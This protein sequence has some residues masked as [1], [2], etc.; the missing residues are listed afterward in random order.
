MKIALINASPKKVESASSTILN[1]LKSVLPSEYSIEDFSIHSPY[2]TEEEIKELS[3]YSVWVFAF[4]LYV[5]GIPSHLLSCLCQI[6]QYGIKDK[7]IRVYSIVNSGFYEGKQNSN[8]LEILKNWCDKVGFTWGM[9]IGF[10]GGGALASMK[11]V[12][13]GKGPKAAFGKSCTELSNVVVAQ[14]SKENVYITIGFPRILYKM[15]AEIGWKQMIKAN[16]G[17]KK[18]LDRRV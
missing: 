4:P 10:G 11:G 16:G 2:M 7:D 3:D 14:K 1:D 15:A 9:G 12:P 13:L 6:E 8:A 17:K 18:D 5:D